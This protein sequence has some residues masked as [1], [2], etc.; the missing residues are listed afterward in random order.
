LVPAG[1]RLLLLNPMGTDDDGKEVPLE[2]VRKNVLG[3]T[4]VPLVINT[5]K[6]CP[7][8]CVLLL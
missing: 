7:D 1:S 8:D 6:Q 3:F 5:S 4:Q 2:A